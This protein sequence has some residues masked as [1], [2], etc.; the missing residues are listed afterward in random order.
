[1]GAVS[2]EMRDRGYVD[3]KRVATNKRPIVFRENLLN[4]CEPSVVAMVRL[5]WMP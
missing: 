1:M 5:G 3:G 4:F 2:C